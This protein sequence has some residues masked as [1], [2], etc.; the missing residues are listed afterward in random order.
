MIGSSTIQFIILC[1]FSECH[2]VLNFILI[3]CHL[4]GT[5][6]EDRIELKYY[7]NNSFIRVSVITNAN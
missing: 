1:I 2:S 3:L 6:Y 5:G 7:K 4:Q